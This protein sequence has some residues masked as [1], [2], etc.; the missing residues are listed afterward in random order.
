MSTHDY[1]VGDAVWHQISRSKDAW[2]A[3]VVSEVKS[4]GLSDAYY[5]N[6]VTVKSS[7]KKQGDPIWGYRVGSMLLQRQ[8]IMAVPTGTIYLVNTRI[9][10]TLSPR[11]GKDVHF[12]IYE[13][14]TRAMTSGNLK[15]YVIVP[16]WINDIR[17][18]YTLD[19][20]KTWTVGPNPFELLS[21]LGANI[22]EI[23]MTRKELFDQWQKSKSEAL[24][25]AGS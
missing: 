13:C 24:S 8:A 6:H 16:G 10:Q 20:Y 22:P 7:M 19:G 12:E 5:D 15:G 3:A 2:R 9:G 11:M 23:V 25:T 14:G 4:N 18:W 17:N 1:K 21:F